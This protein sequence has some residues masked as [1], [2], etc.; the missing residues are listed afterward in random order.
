MSDYKINPNTRVPFSNNVTYCV[1][2]GR[3]GLALQREYFEQLKLV[4][5]QIGFRYIAVTDCS[6]RT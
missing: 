2:T 6:M 1:G 3:I 5:E 4:Q